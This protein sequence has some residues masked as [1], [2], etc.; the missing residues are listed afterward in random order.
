MIDKNPYCLLFDSDGTLVDSEALNTQAV[1]DELAVHGIVE[2]ASALLKQY[3]GWQ[4]KTVLDDLA[5]RHGRAFDQTFE[6]SCRARASNYFDL[7]L[8]AVVHVEEALQQL[9]DAKCIASNA[10]MSKLI[11]VLNK[12]GLIGFFN[13]QV[14]SAYDVGKFKPDPGLFLH[15]AYTMGFE[16]DQCIVIEDSVVGV[17][18]ALAAGMK[19]VWYCPLSETSSALGHTGESHAV[20]LARDQRTLTSIDSMLALPLAVQTLKE[21]A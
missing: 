13:N 5:N 19:C 10:P 20:Q 1:A 12:T 17:H 7:N 14:F 21:L 11:Q 4:F 16:A 9:T 8:Q 2:D 15:A 6:Q 3:R 18:A